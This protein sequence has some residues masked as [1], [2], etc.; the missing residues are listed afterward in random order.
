MTIEAETPTKGAAEGRGR[1]A[2]VGGVERPALRVLATWVG[3]ID[4]QVDQG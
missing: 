1:T 3:S 2:G 4:V